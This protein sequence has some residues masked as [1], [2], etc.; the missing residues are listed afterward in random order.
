VLPLVLGGL[1]RITGVH[2][3]AGRI[4]QVLLGVAVVGLVYSVAARLFGLAAALL[5]T[6]LV[7]LNPYLIFI[8][9][10]L[11]TEN[12][13][14]LLL[15]L[16]VL[17]LS[18]GAAQGFAGRREALASGLLLGVAGLTRPNAVLLLGAAVPL[19]LLARRDGPGRRVA[20]C[21]VCTAAVA[22]AILPWAVRNRAE[23]GEWVI[24]TTHGGITFY[25]SNNRL[26]CEEPAMLGSVA[27]REM[28]PGWAEIQAASELEG[29][30]EAWRRAKQFL[31][32]N[33][34]LMPCLA[35]H[36][37]M[38]FWR[39]RS[40]APASGVKGG[41]WW[42]KGKTL[43]RLA[44]SVDVGIVYAI[45][46]IPSFLVGL[47]VTAR[48]WRRLMSLYGLIAVHLA[49][50]LVFYGSLRARLPIEP[51]IAMFASAGLVRLA[52]L[53]RRTGPGGSGAREGG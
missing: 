33:P 35:G 45:V 18:K 46:V 24:F 40:H 43:G 4:L 23:L 27:P 12:L 44:S 47:A 14:T 25:Q 51:V 37:F 42:D 26:V 48:D 28:L 10:Y 32:E 16:I 9:S 30:R 29:D 31:R 17:V 21:I 53:V 3:A 8:S 50:A 7:A 5:A 13:Y 20:A 22:L 36:K 2:V 1:Y 39:L 34:G 15:L 49:V 6:A 38:R 52:A 11:L 41:W 19:I